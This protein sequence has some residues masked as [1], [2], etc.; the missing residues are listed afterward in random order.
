MHTCKMVLL[1]YSFPGNGEDLSPCTMTP[2]ENGVDM[3]CC[4]VP[5][6]NNRGTQRGSVTNYKHQHLT[7]SSNSKCSVCTSKH[8]PNK[9]PIVV[10][11]IKNKLLRVVSLCSKHR[12][13]EHILKNVCEFQDLLQ[14][15]S[16][17]NNKKKNF[18][19]RKISKRR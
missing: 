10:P 17:N 11:D 13:P 2:S 19:T 8:T 5:Y 7:C 16:F 6:D 9:P 3:C 12:P 1:F 4:P 18:N 14:Q 15:V